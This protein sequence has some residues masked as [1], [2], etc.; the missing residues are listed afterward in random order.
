MW[1]YKKICKFGEEVFDYFNGKVN[2]KL[3]ANSIRFLPE[4]KI[5]LYDKS[6]N[7]LLQSQL[8]FVI[9][10]TV[11]FN[12]NEIKRIYEL[13]KDEFNVELDKK[14]LKAMIIKTIIHELS[15]MDQDI[16][17]SK[18]NDD[19][20]RYKIEVAN[21]ERT[22]KYI[23]NNIT[24]IE[25]RFGELDFSL[26]KSIYNEKKIEFSIT[27]DEIKYIEIK[28]PLD[29]LFSYL[30]SILLLDLK[31]L[32]N[33]CIEH[34]YDEYNIIIGKGRRYIKFTNRIDDLLESEDSQYEF[35]DIIC[36]NLL[37][38]NAYIATVFIIN[39]KLQFEFIKISSCDSTL[40]TYLALTPHPS[41]DFIKNYIIDINKYNFI[42]EY[43]PFVK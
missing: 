37:L 30:G 10:D 41:A 39:N 7:E 36:D 43:K 20:E 31:R 19:R 1:N 13:Y 16:D 29:K 15:H 32:F 27:D 26:E 3:K 34:H 9:L 6:V 35:M 25:D 42:K 28:S 5:K 22:D 4:R 38:H 23:S 40:Q 8:G 24:K 14:Y 18:V 21:D 33:E 11:Y 12:V 2:V 17:F